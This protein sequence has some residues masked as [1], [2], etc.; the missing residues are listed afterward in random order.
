MTGSIG[1]LGYP[2]GT[3]GRSG[4][5]VTG[6]TLTKAPFLL[7]LPGTTNGFFYS[8]G[9]WAVLNPIGGWPLETPGGSVGVPAIVGLPPVNP[10]GYSTA[11][12][13]KRSALTG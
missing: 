12:R 11:T 5:T 10:G 4:A 9:I 6:I 8:P 7:G 2:S 3:C 1:G 13:T